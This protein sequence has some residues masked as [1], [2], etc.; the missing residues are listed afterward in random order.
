MS[1]SS[2]CIAEQSSQ[3]L[4]Y[5]FCQ[6]NYMYMYTIVNGNKIDTVM[7]MDEQLTL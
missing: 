5:E 2:D 4:I 1:G 6:Y 7:Y 3:R